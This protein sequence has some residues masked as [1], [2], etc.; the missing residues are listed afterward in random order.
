MFL[1]GNNTTLRALE[2]SDADLLY[3]WEN[4]MSLWPVSF[5]QVPFSKFILEEFVNSAHNDIYTN[6]QLR[7]MVTDLVSD[8][9]IGIVDLF[10]FDPQNARAGL[11]IY[12]HSDF[13]KRGSAA[14]C[15]ELMKNYAF[16]ILHLKQL[17]V[18][19]NE[20]NEAS[21]ALFEKSGFEKSGLKK[22]WTKSGISDFE[23]V[24]FLQCINPG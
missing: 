8:A 22:A 24:W 15:I 4:D 5:T 10:E 13:R 9:I 11:G 20:S 16:T 19:I 1:K 23:N 18:H 17:Y 2:P 21:I 12:I 6:K 7:L 14:E 3:R